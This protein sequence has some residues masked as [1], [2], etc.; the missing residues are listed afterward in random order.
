M[1]DNPTTNAEFFDAA[2]AVM[3]GG[4]SHRYRWKQPNPIY[5]DRAR[6]AYKWDIEGR[7]YIDYKMGSASQMLGHCHPD[8]VDA[9]REQA[10]R[11]VLAADC[12]PLEVAWAQKI[13]GMIPSIET[14]RFVASGTEASM[15][16]LRVARAFTGR[17]RILRVD[18][19][20]HGWHDH[21][22]RGTTA[23]SNRAATLGV[24]A[25]IEDLTLVCGADRAAIAAAVA[26]NPDIAAI[27]VEASGASYGSVPMAEDAL[28]AARAAADQT[29]ALFILDEVI[30]GFRWS[31]GGRQQLA[32]VRPDMTT[33]AKIATGGM[34]GG[35]LG[36]RRDVMA[37][38]DPAV[39]TRGLKPA[40]LHQGT[41]NGAPICAAAACVMLDHLADGAPQ[42]HA[43][44]I[45]NAL[46]E[47]ITKL[48]RAK[49]IAGVCYGESSTW[50]LY[51]GEEFD[52]T[53]EV[54]AAVL[55]GF[56]PARAAA[57]GRAL[58]ARGVDPMSA[59]SGVT[60]AAHTMAD[61]DETLSA[62]EAAFETLAADGYFG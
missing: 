45:A 10:G 43:E 19:H 41:F 49:G 38:L 16:A 34:P 36:G 56:D 9:L 59:M 51:F 62:F 24:P 33:L 46:R 54:P 53:R 13:C 20:Y 31:P 2:R 48:M 55:R 7:R 14:V 1:K 52:G 3:P 6:G 27:I 32:A 30:T 60:S 50:H 61:V 26:A 4:I 29:G 28:H 5:V 23:G 57:L 58:N 25:A 44:Q 37:M 40:V 39:E 12:H 35:A 21:T 11:L 47:N 8:I 17:D 18:A 15:L 42:A 22:M